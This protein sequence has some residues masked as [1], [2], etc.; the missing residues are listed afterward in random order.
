MLIVTTEGIAQHRIVKPRDRS[1]ALWCAAVAWEATSWRPALPVGGEIQEYTSLLE[2]ARRHAIDRM[3]KTH[4][5]GAA[6]Y[7]FFRSGLF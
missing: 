3:V 4:S 2:D 6:V 5:Y 1:L 7:S